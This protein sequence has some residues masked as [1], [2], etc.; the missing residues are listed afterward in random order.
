MLRRRVLPAFLV[1]ALLASSR[2]AR[3]TNPQEQQLAQALFEEGRRLM[4]AK[5]FAE[6]CP[7]LAES[8]RLDP[9]GGTL[10][11]LAICHEN[12]G[13]LATAKLDYDEALALATKDGRKDRQQI[14]RERS[15]ALDAS[16]PRISVVVPPAA[17][18]PGLE[19]KLDGLVLGRAAW[20][21][22]TTADPG[23]HVVEASAPSRTSWTANVTVAVAQRKVVEVPPLAALGALPPVDV[24]VVIGGVREA[25]PASPPPP[26]LRFP[27]KRANPVF[28]GA[29]TLT[30]AGLSTS[31]V[32][33]VMALS[34]KSAAKDGGC[35]PDRDY[36]PTAAAYDDADRAR[37]LAWVSTVSLGV[38][39][40]GAITMVIVPSKVASDRS[41]RASVAPAWLGLAGAF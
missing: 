27:P 7:K 36:C 26:A 11:N 40:A 8:Q 18:T 16:I 14:A 25:A 9:G 12:E 21:V 15:A 31:I 32:T 19:V 41:L 1:V 29:L 37:T 20:G 5:R 34:A 38:A 17:E 3:A 13:K 22:A 4:D 28:Y 30:L 23:V 10:L 24:P 39:A 35:V 33:G 2:R 6:A